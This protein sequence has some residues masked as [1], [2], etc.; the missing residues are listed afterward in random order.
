MTDQTLTYEEVVEQALQLTPVEKAQLLE[1]LASTLKQ[2]LASDRK[3][4]LKS[5]YGLW[6]D[7]NIDISAD[8]IDEIRREKCGAI[9]HAR[10]FRY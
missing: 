2:E 8:D 7:L 4:P 1:K 5:L 9:F 3:Q 6:A 10:I